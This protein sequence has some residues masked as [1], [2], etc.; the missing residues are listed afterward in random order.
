MMMMT[1]TQRSGKPPSPSIKVTES[2]GYSGY[3]IERILNI[4]APN[5]DKILSSRDPSVVLLHI[6]TNNMSPLRPPDIVPPEHAPMV[7][8]RLIDHILSLAPHITLIVAKI[9]TSP[10]FVWIEN[11]PVYNAAIP[12]IV[13][14][15]FE[16]GYKVL[17]ADLS[18]V[19]SECVRNWDGSDVDCEDLNGDGVH[20]KDAGYKKM[21]GFWYMSLVEATSRGFFEKGE[22]WKAAIPTP[23]VQRVNGGTG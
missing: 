11:T 17:V 6:G 1:G 16:A 2:E 23:A 15:K 18:S 7:L 21:A 5:I 13:K 9:I 10:N 22:G 14:R 8:E 12:G 3:D 20:P 4:S 19:G